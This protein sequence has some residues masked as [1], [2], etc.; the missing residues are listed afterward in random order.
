[1]AAEPTC[2]RR[3]V[4]AVAHEPAPGRLP[5]GRSDG[6]QTERYG[7]TLSAARV[8][9]AVAGPD[10]PWVDVRVVAETG[11]TN[12]DM[13][14]AAGAGARAGTVLVA[15][16]QTAGRGRLDR[17]WSAPA[18]SGLTF[19][20]LLRP[21]VPLAVWGWLPLLA[22]LAVAD[23]LREVADVP[24]EL[25]WP[26][27]VLVRGRKVAGILAE[28]AGDA[29]VVGVGLNVALSASELPVPTATSLL[30]EGARTT[31]RSDVL[32][33][34][35]RTFAG[36][37]AALESAG[38]DAETAGLAPAYRRRCTTIGRPLRVHLPAGAEL[39]GTGVDVDADG[40]LV[41]D[42]GERRHAVG[43]G[44]VVHVR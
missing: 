4:A 37:V 22:G 36:E 2:V 11:S 16:R 38:G 15:E 28:R 1:M 41:V 30:L 21:A 3:T 44:D 14:A 40:R 23:S 31:D 39:T 18:G 8:L 7:G 6:T 26:N 10:Q 32:V 17:R 19:S 25:K 35:L 13:V 5:A 24:A 27:D 29:L 12:A 9:A 20:T 33:G 42:D 43:A 34:V